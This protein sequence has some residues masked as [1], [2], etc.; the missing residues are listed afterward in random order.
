MVHCALY[1]SYG[2]HR[3]DYQRKIIF[4]FHIFPVLC[5]FV[6][7]DSFR[8]IKEFKRTVVPKINFCVRH[9]KFRTSVY[10]TTSFPFSES[11]NFYAYT[12]NISLVTLWPASSIYDWNVINTSISCSRNELTAIVSLHLYYDLLAEKL[13]KTWLGCR[14]LRILLS[15]WRL[16]SYFIRTRG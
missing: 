15:D 2:N 7:G 11:N 6:C 8:R 5:I 14:S 13:K 1:G 3:L 12:S 10:L 16:N 9:L 4:L